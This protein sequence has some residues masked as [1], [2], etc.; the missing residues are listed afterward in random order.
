MSLHCQYSWTLYL[1][2]IAARKMRWTHLE[3][4]YSMLWIINL[5]DNNN[6]YYADKTFEECSKRQYY[7]VRNKCQYIYKHYPVAVDWITDQAARKLPGC[8][9]SRSIPLQSCKYTES[10]VALLVG[11]ECPG[12]RGAGLHSTKY[13]MGQGL[14]RLVPLP[15]L[16][17]LPPNWSLGT[18][19]RAIPQDLCRNSSVAEILVFGREPGFPTQTL[20]RWYMYK[21]P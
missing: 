8:T 4:F 13:H 16:H 21:L 10:V 9:P 2:V 6:Q 17:P 14:P 12:W 19:D 3:V 11:D 20:Q 15:L 7:W 1:S 5:K 18:L